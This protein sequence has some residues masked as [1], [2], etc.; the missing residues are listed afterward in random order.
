M[1]DAI[2]LLLS[3]PENNCSPTRAKAQIENAVRIRASV[4]MHMGQSRAFTIVF[5]VAGYENSF[6]LKI[7]ITTL[8]GQIVPNFFWKWVRTN[9]KMNID[10][11]F[12]LLYLSFPGFMAFPGISNFCNK[13]TG[14]IPG[15]TKLAANGRLQWEL[16]I[17]VQVFQN[18]NQKKF[19]GLWIF[20]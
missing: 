7:E 10:L 3:I 6:L 16:K 4:I 17:R 13:Y 15:A 5:K 11:N 9:V 1:L 2:H 14:F 20:N 18:F 12:F 8:E 19:C